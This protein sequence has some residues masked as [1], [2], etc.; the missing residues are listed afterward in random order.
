MENA[1]KAL[2]IAAGVLIGVMVLSLGVALFADLQN[3]VESS[4]EQIRFNDL[5]KFNTQFTKYINYIEDEKQFSLTIHDVVTA[6]NTAYENNR[7]NNLEPSEWDE[8]PNSLYVSVYLNEMRIDQNIEETM[9]NLLRDNLKK[10]Y[11]CEG[12]NVEYSSDT[13]RVYRISFYDE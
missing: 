5:S 1:T 4:H 12:K 13:G 8:L 2:F 11:K 7:S 9:T 10:E 3:Y 6:A